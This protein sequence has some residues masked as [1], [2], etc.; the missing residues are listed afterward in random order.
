[1]QMPADVSH[2]SVSAGP[3]DSK[4]RI[5]IFHGYTGGPDEFR[6]IAELAAKRLNAYVH[7]PL[8][9]GHGT[10]EADLIPLTYRDFLDFARTQVR[11]MWSPEADL[12]IFGHSFGGYLAL[13]TAAEFKPKIAV[14]TV[15][16]FGLKFPYS[17]WLTAWLMSF[18]KLWDKRLP[19]H[20]RMSR[21]GLY[22]YNFMPGNS[23]HLVQEGITRC[24]KIISE[25]SCPIFALHTTHDPLT[26]TRSGANVLNFSGNNPHNTSVILPNRE[27]GIFYGAGSDEVVEMIVSFLEKHI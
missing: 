19:I 3:K 22:Y 9:P 26:H 2:M 15:T 12:V 10:N 24:R 27:H 14:V 1:M 4:K 7:V 13:E 21:A 6:N 16:P 5:I 17:M 20:E 11:S 25:I 18:K 23:L 8:L